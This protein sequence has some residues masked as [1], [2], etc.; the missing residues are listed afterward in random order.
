MAE[1]LE[2]EELC[3]F[4]PKPSYDFMIWHNSKWQGNEE[5]CKEHTIARAGGLKLAVLN[6]QIQYF[7]ILGVCLFVCLFNILVVM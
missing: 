1:V 3:L 4:Q 6:F 5:T 2:Q 7:G